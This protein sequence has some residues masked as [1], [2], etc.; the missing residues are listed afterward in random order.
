MSMRR[1][2][3]S[4]LWIAMYGGAELHKLG[5]AGLGR[6]EELPLRLAAWGYAHGARN[7]SVDLG[8]RDV[9]LDFPALALA[10][11]RALDLATLLD[12]RAPLAERHAALVALD[13]S[14]HAAWIG[15]LAL[16]SHAL[17]V[18]SAG[19]AWSL[20]AGRLARRSS[21]GRGLAVT[22]SRSAFD[23]R[24]ARELLVRAERQ[25]VLSLVG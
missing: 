6:I 13:S 25:G 16:G 5:Q 8:G 11:A 9:R 15:V 22:W 10:E 3:S 4:P 20:R 2:R 14:N 19:S 21:N 18:E 7:I 24:L 23:V 17:A 1:A 12:P